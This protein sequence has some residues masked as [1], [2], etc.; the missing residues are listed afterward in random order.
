MTNSGRNWSQHFCR[1]SSYHNRRHSW[2]HSFRFIQ[3][4]FFIFSFHI[5]C[6]TSSI[7]HFL[8]P[9]SYFLPLIPPIQFLFWHCLF[10]IFLYVISISNLRIPICSVTFWISSFRIPFSPIKITMWIFFLLP[11]SDSTLIL[12]VLISL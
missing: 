12:V 10:F 4:P 11:I 6:F 9:I 2:L 1:C 7:F 8:F 5:S 3:F